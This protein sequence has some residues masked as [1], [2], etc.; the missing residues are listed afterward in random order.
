[1]RHRGCLVPKASFPTEWAGLT[2]LRDWDMANAVLSGSDITSVPNDTRLSA[3]DLTGVSSNE[4]QYSS[5]SSSFNSKPSAVITSGTSERFSF[6]D[7]GA[8]S[9]GPV[10]IVVVADVT[11][12]QDLSQYAM[13]LTN[14]DFGIVGVNTANGSDWECWNDSGSFTTVSSGVGKTTAAVL[15]STLTGGTERF[16]VNS[17]TEAGNGGSSGAD[18]SG[19]GVL[20]NYAA[21]ISTNFSLRGEIARVLVFGSVLDSTQRSVCMNA[22]GTKYGITI[23]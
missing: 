20:G 16:Y 18:Y 10:T 8:S 14:E 19:G 21:S 5:S 2:P 23:S 13:S 9:G 6:G 15:V 22:L 12:S 3:A 7:L 17:T 1:M 11:T 4:P